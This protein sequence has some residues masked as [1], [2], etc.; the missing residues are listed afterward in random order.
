MRIQR[1]IFL[2]L[3]AAAAVGA[4]APAATNGAATGPRPA[5]T[6]FTTAAKL[7][8]AQAEGATGERQQELYNQ[9]LQQSLQGIESAPQNPQHFYLAGLSHAGLGNFEAADTMWDRALE[10]FPAY[11][12]DVM[13]AREQAWAQAF[14]QGVNAYNAGN[15]EQAERAWQ[16]ANQIFDRRPEAHFNLAAIYSAEQRY[17]DAINEFRAAVTALEREPGRELTPEEQ[18]DREESL[19]SAL[20]NLGNLQLFTEQFAG[21]EQTFRRLSQVQPDDV[22]TRANLAT[23]LARQGQREQAMAVYNELLGTPGMEPAQ[24]MSIGVGLFQAQEFAQAANAFR[25]ITVAQPNNRDA[26]YNLLNALYAQQRDPQTATAQGWLD[27]VP[28]GERLIEIDPLNEN[29]FLIMIQAHREARQQQR[30]LHFA[31]RNQA[32][33]VYVD[34]IQLRHEDG[35]TTLNAVASGNRARA[36]SPVQLE[37]TFYG[38]DG[39]ALGTQ[40][41]TVTAP[42][43]NA[44][45][46]FQ[47]AMPTAAA[48]TGF[49][50]RVVQ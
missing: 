43:Q 6:R 34:N 30:A 11:E 4:C 45:A 33:P 41:T 23:A 8:L 46:A 28:V 27:L 12:G 39:Q 20:Q 36:G 50:Y 26:W 42:A 24:M 3:A 14:N 17:D 19:A 16:Q 31:E 1:G 7:Q 29:A 9:A 18:A 2:A 47:V 38:A 40:R 5:E 13:V 32:L 35:R 21:A 25:Q 15:M 49:R 10:M 22:Q 37:F 48:P 44:E